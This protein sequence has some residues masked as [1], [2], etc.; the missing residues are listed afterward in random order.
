MRRKAH[1]RCRRSDCSH[2]HGISTIRTE[3][4]AGSHLGSTLRA[5]WQIRTF[6]DSG[7]DVRNGLICLTGR[8]YAGIDQ[9][10]LNQG[11]LSQVKSQVF[12]AGLAD[13][14]CLLNR[15]GSRELQS[16]YHL[17]AAICSGRPQMNGPTKNP[18]AISRI[19]DRMT[20]TFAPSA[21]IRS[22]IRS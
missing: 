5:E 3:S 19:V 2:G 10:F 12:I 1:R 18:A 13:H 4:D 17:I 9:G 7:Y 22:G 16:P 11:L 6:P 21:G 20:I 8:L 14:S 15:V